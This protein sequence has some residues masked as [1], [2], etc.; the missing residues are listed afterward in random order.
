MAESPL[1]GPSGPISMTS[2]GWFVAPVEHRGGRF[3]T[4]GAPFS[5][6][7]EYSLFDMKFSTVQMVSDLVRITKGSFSALEWVRVWGFPNALSGGDVLRQIEA[8]V[9]PPT[10]SCKPGEI[11]L[12]AARVSESMGMLGYARYGNLDP[13][14]LRLDPT[15]DLIDVLKIELNPFRFMITPRIAANGSGEPRFDPDNLA[16]IELSVGP[17]SLHQAIWLHVALLAAGY[18]SR[19]EWRSCRE[20]GTWIFPLHGRQEFCLPYR[21]LG[22]GESRCQMKNSKKRQ[23]NDEQYKSD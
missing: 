22:L 5:N 17:E 2:T 9:N 8:G 7:R 15:F 13:D 20:C 3:Q 18:K 4:T 23:R 6:W 1:V 16:Q 14:W 21:H 11:D 10:G 12:L 19:N